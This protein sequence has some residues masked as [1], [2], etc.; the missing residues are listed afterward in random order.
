MRL[1]GRIRPV[2]AHFGAADGRCGHRA[3]FSEPDGG[4]RAAA[5]VRTGGCVDEK[6]A[7][8][9]VCGGR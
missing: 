3:A 9:R 5:A 1:R 8:E 6:T 7:A 4:G 2:G